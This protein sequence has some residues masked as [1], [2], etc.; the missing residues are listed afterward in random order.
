MGIISGFWW[1]WHRISFR[2]PRFWRVWRSSKFFDSSI[3][4]LMLVGK[5]SHRSLYLFSLGS[6][7]KF[8]LWFGNS[9]NAVVDSFIGSNELRRILRRA[10]ILSRRILNLFGLAWFK[11]ETA[12]RTY[13]TWRPADRCPHT[14]AWLILLHFLFS[15]FLSLLF[16]TSFVGAFVRSII[17]GI[18]FICNARAYTDAY[19][20]TQIASSQWL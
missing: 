3:S 7:W 16:R 15:L 19:T 18:I 10:F 12:G 14:I 11:M 8:S 13:L 5:N 4:S 2:C 17:I 20:H 9:L 6:L 1:I